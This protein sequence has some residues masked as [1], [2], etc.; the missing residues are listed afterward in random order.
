MDLLALTDT[1][2]DIATKLAKELLSLDR[3]PTENLLA[4][5]T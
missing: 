3:V 5:E 1:V 2:M 4:Q